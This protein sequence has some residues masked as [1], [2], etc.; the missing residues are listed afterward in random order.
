[1]EIIQRQANLCHGLADR[2]RLRILYA[3]TEKAYNVSELSARLQLA[4]PVVSRHLKIL[5]DCSAVAFVRQ[6]KAVYY[7]P[8]DSRIVQ[9]LDLLRVYLTDRMKNEGHLAS[10]AAPRP[11]Q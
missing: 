9:A 6:G 8:A 5:R 10:Q 7:S 11:V 3:L 2:Q 1:M 4:Q